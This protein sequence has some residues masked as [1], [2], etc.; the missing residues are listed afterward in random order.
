MAA[1]AASTRLA[2][3]GAMTTIPQT[4][5]MRFWLVVGLC[6]VGAWS[7]GS[8]DADDE[9]IFP[10]TSCTCAGVPNRATP[11]FAC[12]SSGASPGQALCQEFDSGPI[13]CEEPGIDDTT[14]SSP[15]GS[16][17]VG[18]CLSSDGENCALACDCAQ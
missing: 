17:E 16:C 9:N 1:R 7:V 5:P 13:D 15:G 6:I 2:D 3:G 4:R 12:I 11:T 8:C 18:F 14:F 10:S